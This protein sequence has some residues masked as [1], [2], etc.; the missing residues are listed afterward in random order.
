MGQEKGYTG[1]KLKIKNLTVKYKGK[2]WRP[3]VFFQGTAREII[4]MAAYYGDLKEEEFEERHDW[5]VIKKDLEMGSIYIWVYEKRDMVEL[6][7]SR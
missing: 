4:K 3:I 7:D 2:E 1:L 5:L 6:S